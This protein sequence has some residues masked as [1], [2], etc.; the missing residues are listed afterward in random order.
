[1]T[2]INVITKFHRSC[3]LDTRASR[4]PIDSLQATTARHIITPATPAIMLDDNCPHDAPE[5]FATTTAAVGAAVGG[6]AL[7]TLSGTGAGPAALNGLLAFPRPNAA[8]AFGVMG[9]TAAAGDMAGELEPASYRN[10][11]KLDAG[12][13]ACHFLTCYEWRRLSA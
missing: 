12:V 11:A 2:K 3:E 8:T 4:S 9:A 10:I 13:G 6:T 1:L 7:M 5:D